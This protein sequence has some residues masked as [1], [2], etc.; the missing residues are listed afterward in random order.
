MRWLSLIPAVV[1]MLAAGVAP[2]TATTAEPAE[3]PALQP[4]PSEAAPPVDL[5]G[6][7]CDAKLPAVSLGAEPAGT[8]AGA[9][10]APNRWGGICWPECYYCQTQADCIWGGF[11]RQGVQCP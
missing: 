1:F 2:L 11:C 3:V 4:Q 7:L 10:A 5:A 9:P 8:E 6:L